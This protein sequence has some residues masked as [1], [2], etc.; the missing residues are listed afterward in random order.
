MPTPSPSPSPSPA[1]LSP[2]DFDLTPLDALARLRHERHLLEARQ[3]EMEKGRDQISALVFERVKDDYE[4][5]ARELGEE[6]RRQEQRARA[7][8]AKLRAILD[9]LAA[10]MLGAK[11]DHEELLVRHRLGEVESSEYEG[12]VEELR[13]RQAAAAARL[14]AVRAIETA[15]TAALGVIVEGNAACA[16]AAG[17]SMLQGQPPEGTLILGKRNGT[18]RSPRPGSPGRAAVG[19]GSSTRWRAASPPSAAIRST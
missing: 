10:S 15:F 7:E 8:H 17:S 5:K 4:Q 3:E 14:E 19:R 13:N 1:P 16:T 9:S 6:S 18:A 2:P 11:L 12:L